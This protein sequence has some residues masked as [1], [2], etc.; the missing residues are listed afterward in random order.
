MSSARDYLDNCLTETNFQGIGEKSKGKV[1]DSYT[2]DGKRILITTDRQSAFDHVLASVPL[3][4]QVLNQ[5]T[6]WWFDQVKDIVPT[7]IISM[8]D[9]NVAIARSCAVYPVEVIVRGYITGVT[10]TSAWY[11]Y[12]RGEHDFCGVRLPEGLVKNQK[13]ATP[14]ITPTTKP[15]TNSGLHDEKISPTEIVDRGL[16]QQA[17]W[18]RVAA[19]A[20]RLFDRGTEIA[21]RYGLILVDTK[22]EFGEDAHGNITLIDEVHTPDSSRYWVEATYADKFA[23]GQEPD[24]LDKEFLRLWLKDQGYLGEGEPP[25]I[26]DDVRAGIADK[27]INLYERITGQDFS[28]PDPSVSIVERIYE[29]LKKEFSQIIML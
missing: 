19:I 26:P 17:T 13:F 28:Y 23:A 12:E 6:T 8:P 21:S 4:G 15:E 2:L 9:P 22:Y 29:N 10:T 20:L 11:N 7:H 16:M 18:D 24:Y 1:R 25:V 27:Y 5:I 3:K 14:I